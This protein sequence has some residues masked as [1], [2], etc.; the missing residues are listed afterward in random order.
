MLRGAEVLFL[1]FLVVLS[2][3]SHFYLLTYNSFS[4]STFLCTLGNV[5][6]HGPQCLFTNMVN[7]F[8][9]PYSTFTHIISGMPWEFL[10]LFTQQESEPVEMKMKR[11]SIRDQ[12]DP[13]MDTAHKYV[14]FK[15]TLKS[16]G[17]FDF[18]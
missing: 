14:S 11:S 3:F 10:K 17:D 4:Y 6:P 13:L 2:E 1:T 8:Q 15:R 7:I 16:R 5:V 9:I 12:P 18:V